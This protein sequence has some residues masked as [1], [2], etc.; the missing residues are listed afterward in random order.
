MPV[1]ADRDLSLIK[2]HTQY[3]K[4]QCEE[5]YRK[6]AKEGRSYESIIYEKDGKIA[7]ITLNRPEK[8]N[9]LN[10]ALY[11]DLLAGLGEASQDPDVR[12]IVIKG[13]GRAFCSG[14]D[15]S[16]PQ[17]DESPPIDPKYHPTVRDFFQFER[18]RCQKY[19][20]IMNCPKATIAQ[21]HGFCIGAGEGIQA[22]C[23]MTIAAED[24][25]FGT[26]GFS[27]LTMGI[28][29][30]GGSGAPHTWPGGSERYRAGRML[31]EI[32]GKEAAELS[33]IN[34]AVPADE[35]EKEVERWAQALS[36][37]PPERLAIVKE[38]INGTL[39][40]T[41][42]GNAFRNHYNIHLALQFI[43]F[44][45]NETNLYKAR[46]DKGL[47]G[48]IQTRAEHATPIQDAE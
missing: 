27:R 1:F 18:R 47:K 4:N 43:R 25:Q 21:V 2:W 23:D 20:D 37:I 12:V 48:F 41:G 36:L 28:T 46:R 34:K 10:D 22:S 33:L 31:P 17:G 35:L 40:I 44:R 32:S 19:E 8:S 39:D 9:A 3:Q 7:R 5:A 15:L 38:G 42:L 45:P 24:A 30:M 26:R 6:K 29:A 13:S 16:S 11:F 14:H